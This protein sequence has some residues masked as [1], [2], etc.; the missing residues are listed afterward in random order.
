MSGFKVKMICAQ[1]AGPSG[2]VTW[3]PARCIWHDDTETAHRRYTDS[4]ADLLWN[5]RY[6][7][8]TDAKLVR[9]R[10]N[11]ISAPQVDTRLV[12]N[13]DHMYSKHEQ[14]IAAMIANWLDAH[15]K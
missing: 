13:A 11:A 6:W 10:E 5:Q 15:L 2:L 7:Y 9:I 12:A 3:Q 4:V 1:C 14:E 8:C